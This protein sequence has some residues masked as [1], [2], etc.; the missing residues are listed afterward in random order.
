M[1]GVP[2]GTPAQDVIFWGQDDTFFTCEGDDSYLLP[3]AELHRLKSGHFAVE[4]C[5]PMIV[6]RW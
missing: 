1:A 4:D 2:A 5:L 6:K 3:N